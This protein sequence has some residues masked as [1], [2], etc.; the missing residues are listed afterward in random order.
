MVDG[1]RLLSVCTLTGTAGSNPAAS[2]NYNIPGKICNNGIFSNVIPIVKASR[3]KNNT[4][5]KKVAYKLFE[6]K[7]SAYQKLPVFKAAAKLNEEATMK[8]FLGNLFGKKSVARLDQDAN[9]G[10]G[11]IKMI[12]DAEKKLAGLRGI[13]LTDFARAETAVDDYVDGLVSLVGSV[14]RADTPEVRQKA[15]AL[16]SKTKATFT[17]LQKALQDAMSKLTQALP[18]NSPLLKGADAAD[19]DARKG[20]IMQTPG[21]QLRGAASAV[22]GGAGGPGASRAGQ[23]GR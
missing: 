17:G 11:V 23:A 21:Q 18:A 1:G 13:P 8:E 20:A 19:L 14:Q 10:S 12:G 7:L 15:A 16:F 2:A 3:M 4:V 22:A 9:A 5:P 6:S